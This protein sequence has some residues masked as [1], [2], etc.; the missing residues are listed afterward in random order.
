MEIIVTGKNVEVSGQIQDY[1]ERKLKKLGNHLPALNEFKVE[2][3][4]ERTKSLED[5]FVVQVTVNSAGTLLRGESRA[6][7]VLSAIDEVAK[8]INRQAERFKGRLYDKGKG[9]S[10]R[11]MAAGQEPP[12]IARVKRFPVAPLTPEEAAEQMEML[13]HSFFLFLN[14]ASDRVNLIYRRQ[15]GSYGLIEPVVS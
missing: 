11:H 9:L 4:Q 15:N 13:G 14:L 3:G 7:N 10:L 5:R 2:I 8:V 12:G 1:V 6:V